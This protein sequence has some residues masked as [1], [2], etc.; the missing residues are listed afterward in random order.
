MFRSTKDFTSR[1]AACAAGPCRGRPAR[2]PGLSLKTLLAAGVATSVLFAIAD[3]ARGDLIIAENTTIDYTIPPEVGAVQIVDGV[4]PPTV[5]EVVNPAYLLVPTHVRGQSVLNIRAGS[6]GP[7]P[8]AGV[9]LVFGYDTATINLYDGAFVE[10]DEFTLNGNAVL[11]IYG[12]IMK[13]DLEM[14][15]GVTNVYGGLFPDDIH[16]HGTAT[17]H[18]FGGTFERSG[19]PAAMFFVTDDAIAY[20]Y[21]RDYHLPEPGRLV[22]TLFDGSPID[23]RVPWDSPRVFLIPEPSALLISAAGLA[24]FALARSLGVC[25]LRN[26]PWQPRPSNGVPLTEGM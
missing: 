15:T 12:G 17:I 6:D 14:S 23:I 10:G 4:A 7:D 11:N 26:W 20:I 2:P 24:A 9:A 1:R 16:A 13:D 3:P 8:P 22:G 21:L 25:A 19:E 5:V 18:L